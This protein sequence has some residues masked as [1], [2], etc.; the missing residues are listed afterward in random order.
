MV[1]VAITTTFSLVMLGVA[2]VFCFYIGQETS[3]V[4]GHIT[5]EQQDR[6]AADNL[7]K[8]LRRA[9]SVSAYTATSITFLDVDNNPVVLAFD[10]TSNLLTL[11]KANNLISR[12]TGCTRMSFQMY[13]ETVGT[14]T[15]D[16]ATAASSAANCR[17]VQVNWTLNSNAVYRASASESLQTAKIVFRNH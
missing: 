2:I 10:S 16:L 6:L 3:S 17:A 15:L 11:T 1:E 14:G 13:Q 9:R 7:T 5:Q 8:Y 12:V 4:N